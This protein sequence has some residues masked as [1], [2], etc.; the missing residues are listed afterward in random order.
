MQNDANVVHFKTLSDAALRIPA[1]LVPVRDKAAQ[2]LNAALQQLFDNADDALFE[3][4]DR[5]TSNNEQNL[6]F[7]AMRDLRLKRKT[8]ERNF[9][10]RY[11]ERFAGLNH[12]ETAKNTAQLDAISF[13]FFHN[14]HTNH[15]KSNTS[16]HSINMSDPL[17]KDTHTKLGEKMQ[18]DSTK[19]TSSKLGETFTDA[20]DKFARGVVPDS[21]KSTSQSASDKLGRSSDRTAH[22]SSGGSVLD[23]A[24]GAL[25]LDKH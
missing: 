15:T 16:T 4:A 21:E 13:E 10:Q 1:A 14:N 20:G 5:A 17:R 2:R 11:F 8:I 18:P 6:F 9:L 22:G 3:M 12:T 7:E 23:K 25:G 19:S 24:K